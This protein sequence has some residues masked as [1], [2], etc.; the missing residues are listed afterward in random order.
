MIA[1]SYETLQVPPIPS[2]FGPLY[3]VHP[4]EVHWPFFS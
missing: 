3:H 1:N 2:R 4:R